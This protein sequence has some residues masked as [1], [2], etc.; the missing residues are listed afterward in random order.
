MDVNTKTSSKKQ[1]E[2]YTGTLSQDEPPKKRMKFKH[3]VSN[4]VPIQMP[5]C[6]LP[7]WIFSDSLPQKIFLPKNITL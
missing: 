6:P 7:S 1:I 4:K 2:Y 5:S 3:Q